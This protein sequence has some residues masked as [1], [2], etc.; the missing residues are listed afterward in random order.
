MIEYIQALRHQLNEYNYAYYVLDDPLVPD[1]EYDR[2]FQVLQALERQHPELLTPDSPTQRVGS[3]PLLAF[4]EVQHA[5]PMLS[6]NNAF[7]T[8]AIQA[9]DTRIH[10]HLL[11]EEVITY[12]C[13][14]K[15][16]GLAVSLRY[17]QGRLVCAATRGDGTVG[18]NI[19][20]N[21]RTIPSIPLVLRGD[22]I[23]DE[24]E[25][26]G[27]VYMPLK[28]FRAFN[29][30]Q[31]TLG[32]K[33]FANPRNAAA[34]SLRQLDSRVTATRPLAMMAYGLGKTSRPIAMQHDE[35]LKKLHAWGFRVSLERRICVGIDACEAYYQVLYAQRHDVDYEM[36]GVVIKVNDFRWQ[37]ELGYISRAPRWA[38]AYKFPAVEEI[39]RVEAVEFQV[40]RTGVLTPVAR[41][42]PVS[43]GGVTVS[44]A[45][46]HNMDEVKRKQIRVGDYVI[47][48]RAGDVIPEVVRVIIEKR[49]ENT[50]TIEP[51][52]Q[53]P[54]CQ[55]TV[56]VED[57]LL[58]CMGGLYCSAQ[59]KATIRHFASRKA[60]DI[61]G[62]GEKLIDQLIDE[63]LI[64]TVVDLFS[65]QLESL[66]ALDRMGQKS[67]ENLLAALEKAKSTTLHRFI[68]ALGIREVGETTA[69]NLARHFGTIDALMAATREALLAVDD[70]GPVV[71]DHIINFFSVPH[72]RQI[73]CD[74]IKVGVH[75]PAIA[76]VKQDSPFSG[77]VVVLTGS[78]LWMTREQATQ[79]LQQLG[80]KVTNSVSKKTD[81]VIAGEGA[82]SKLIKAQNLGVRIITE[83]D[84]KRELY[85]N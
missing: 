57:A 29:Q 28:A 27:E 16:D 55:S 71:S 32:Q 58:R 44:N 14:P 77:K 64:E 20:D 2:L 39:T 37:E 50:C 5:V 18:E 36:D 33:V 85:T 8:A 3:A 76:A 35:A 61:E 80:A 25:V 67:A 38:I 63:R 53:C 54:V 4:A 9:F 13:E 6:L 81:I 11:I 69:L 72:H 31:Q 46:L 65:L 40:G 24:L 51:P 42:V 82:G 1:V 66:A 62:L 22:D 59:R 23:P 26:R 49:P 19:T 83:A 48:R 41:L 45:T 15:L 73:I 75:W 74:L 60:M 43:V 68:Y 52:A 34:G 79:L 12:I 84:W 17:E 7:D 47:I 21:C 70:I 10:E 56:A 78:L 30:R